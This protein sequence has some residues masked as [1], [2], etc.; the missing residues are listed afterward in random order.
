[1]IC[2]SSLKVG[3][4]VVDGGGIGDVMLDLIDPALG[5]EE[6][7]ALAG[8]VDFVGR[9]AIEVEVDSAEERGAD[10]W[11]VVEVVLVRTPCLGFGGVLEDKVVDERRRIAGAAI[12]GLGL[13]FS[14][15]DFR[16]PSK[17]SSDTSIECTGQ[18]LVEKIGPAKTH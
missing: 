7:G 5:R 1:M 8:L 2:S 11:E 4:N 14:F 12:A 16:T 10:F 18:T 17:L 13:K 6:V 15:L 3:N 9:R